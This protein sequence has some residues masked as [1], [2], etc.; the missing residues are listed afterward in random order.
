MVE[1][2]GEAVV[3]YARQIAEKGTAIPGWKLVNGKLGNRAWRDELAAADAIKAAGGEPWETK[4]ISPAVA[5]KAVGKAVFAAKLAPLTS[6]APGSVSLVPE[7]DKRPA[8]ACGPVA[9]FDAI[10]IQGTP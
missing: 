7:S 5:E 1:A 9:D 10:P 3:S 8:I 6:R 4:V 2:W